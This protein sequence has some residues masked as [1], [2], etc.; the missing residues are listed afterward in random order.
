MLCLAGCSSRAFFPLNILRAPEEQKENV[1]V[2]SESFHGLGVYEPE[3]FVFSGRVFLVGDSTVCGTYSDMRVESQDLMGWGKYLTYYFTQETE[4]KG[5][6]GVSVYNFALSGGSSRSYLESEGYTQ[7]KNYL[8]KGDYLFIQFG[9]NDQQIGTHNST[10]ATLSRNDVV[11]NEK[12]ES[13]GKNAL[14]TYS[15]EWILYEKYIKFARDRGAVPILVSPNVMLNVEEGRPNTANHEPYRAVMRALAEEFSVP[16]V[17]LTDLSYTLYEEEA[18]QGGRD[19]LLSMHAY[20]DATRT[21]VDPAH[22]SRYGAFRIAG[23]VAQ[24]IAETDVALSN[25]VTEP[26]KLFVPRKAN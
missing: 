16:F 15:F 19:R 11:V 17:D 22:L 21:V 25:F 5:A 2:P 23:L 3:G 18:L 1:Y 4:E 6:Q 14:G 7:L 13:E 10:S 8:G 26:Q 9:H 24:K 12:G 20:T